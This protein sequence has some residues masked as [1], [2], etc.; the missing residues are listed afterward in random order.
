MA[1]YRV[2]RIHIDRL[3]KTGFGLTEIPFKVLSYDTLRSVRFGEGRINREC[4][5]SGIARGHQ[6]LGWR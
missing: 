5:L 4:L 2:G 1:G 3:A 6:C